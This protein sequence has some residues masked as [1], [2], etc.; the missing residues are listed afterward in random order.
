MDGTCVAIMVMAVTHRSTHAE[1]RSP[2]GLLEPPAVPCLSLGPAPL[3]PPGQA[4][5]LLADRQL[6]RECVL[7]RRE[8]EGGWC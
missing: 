7:V 4:P 2:E 1:A 8:R 6:V 3:R 5:G